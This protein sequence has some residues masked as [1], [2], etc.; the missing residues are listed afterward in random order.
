MEFT[1]AAPFLGGFATPEAA[2]DASV[3]L[4][5]P[6]EPLRQLI[7]KGA[8]TRKA[9]V[10]SEYE[11][12]TALELLAY[13]EP[14]DTVPPFVIELDGAMTHEGKTLATV[15]GERHYHSVVDGRVVR[16]TLQPADTPSH[17][18]L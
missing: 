11:T 4:G 8:R 17:P 6:N 18:H 16:Y 5:A 2:Y 1:D 13:G 12:L 7:A 15:V 14:T 10:A 9:S 3:D